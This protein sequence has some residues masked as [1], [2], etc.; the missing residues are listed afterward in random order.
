MGRCKLC[1]AFTHN[2]ADYKIIFGSEERQL[3]V[4]KWCLEDL[5]LL[6]FNAHQ[7]ICLREASK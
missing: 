5:T 4:C 6:G 3:L 1:Y 7:I 2:R